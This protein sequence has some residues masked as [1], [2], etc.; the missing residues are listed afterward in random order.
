MKLKTMLAVKRLNCKIKRETLKFRRCKETLTQTVFT[1]DGLPHS[2]NK[3][4]TIDKLLPTALDIESHIHQLKAVRNSVRKK[5][6]KLLE[7]SF[8]NLENYLFECETLIYR[9]AFDYSY[10]EIARSINYS[11]A[12]VYRFHRTGLLTLGFTETDIHTLECS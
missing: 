2:P 10:R 5:L 7:K 11:V 9:Y 3:S 6:S 1:S 8:A 4:S 12:S